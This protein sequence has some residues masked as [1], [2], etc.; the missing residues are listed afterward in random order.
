MGA[1]TMHAQKLPIHLTLL[2]SGT[3]PASPDFLREKERGV[4]GERKKRERVCLSP[5]S[6]LETPAV[7][8]PSPENVPAGNTRCVFSHPP[9]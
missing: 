8:F 5:K 3:Y 9:S 2:Y 4:Q 7:F 6:G 1:I